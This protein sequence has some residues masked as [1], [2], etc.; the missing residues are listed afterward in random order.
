MLG[1]EGVLVYT[2][3]TVVFMVC[4]CIKFKWI[5][6]SNITNRV[7]K[8]KILPLILHDIMDYIL[9]LDTWL[10]ALFK[11]YKYK[12]TTFKTKLNSIETYIFYNFT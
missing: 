10:Y 2:F 1:K 6:K 5:K 8:Y 3:K 11:W 7:Q 9:W 12:Y 4:S